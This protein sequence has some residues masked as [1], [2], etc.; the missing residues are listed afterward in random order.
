MKARKVLS[1]ITASVLAWGAFLPIVPQSAEARMETSALALSWQTPIGEGTTLQKYYKSYANQQISIMVTKVDLNNPY[2]EVKPVY[3]TK[4]KLT[5]RQSVTNMAKETGAVAAINVDFFNMSKR[6]APFGIVMKDRELISSMGLISYWYSLGLTGDKTAMIEKF[7]FT[8][9]VTAQNGAAYPLQGVNKEE[10]NPSEGRKSHFNQM[11]LYTPKFGKTSLGQIPGYNTVE[12]VFRNN[13]A[14]EVRVNQPGAPIPEDG[15]VL[16]GNGPAAV[17]LQQNFPVGSTAQV[18]YATLPN[19][20]D[21]A[22]AV[23]GSILLVDQGVAKTSFQ[24]DSYLK[25][26]NARTAVGISQDGKTLYMVTVDGAKPVYLEE[27]A[28]IMVELGAWRALNL[29]GGGSTTHAA[30]MLGET[31]AK[32]VSQPKE[33]SER[34]VPTGLAVYNTAPPGELAGFQIAGPTE[35]LMGQTATFTTK[36]WDTHYLPYKI[37]PSD[38]EWQAA[39]SEAGSFAGNVF[40]A[41]RPGIAS[42]VA[43]SNG[44]AQ[45]RDIYVITGQD[46]AQVVVSPSPINMVPGQTLTLDVKV[47]TKKGQTINATPQSVQVWSDSD[48]ITVDSDKLQLIAGDQPGTANITVSYDGVSTT[49]PVMSGQEIEVPWL[50]FDNQTSMYHVGHPASISAYGS[51]KTVSGDADLVYRTKKS[52]QLS[53]NFAGA[54]TTDVRI[55]YG[56]VGANPVTIPGNPIGIGLWVNGDGSN[57]WLRAEVVDAKGKLTY[58]DLAKEIN[59]TGWKQVKG[60][61][62]GGVTYPLQLKSI[63]VVD[64]PDDQATQEQGVLYFDEVSLLLP[65]NAATQPAGREVVPA[66]PGTLSLGQEL[67]MGYSLQKTAGFLAKARID[68]KSVAGQSMPGYV[69]A[70]Y[71]FTLTPVALQAGQQDQLATHPVTITLTPKKWMNGKGVGLMYVNEVNNTLDMLMGQVDAKGNWVYEINSYGTYIPYYLDAPSG[72]AFV[73]IINHPAQAE[74]T[75]LANRGLVKGMDAY[76][77]GPEVPLTRA[78]FVTLLGRAFDWKL[79]A[80]P[81]VSFKDVIPDYAKGSVQVAVSKGLVKGYADKTFRPNQTVTRAEAAVILDRVLQKKA[82]PKTAPADKKSWPQW[83]A[84]SINNMAGLGLID[85]QNNRFEPNKP[86]TRAVTAVALYRSLE[87]N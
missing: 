5:E 1:L 28:D 35:M 43:E 11:N 73:D 9:Q 72:V 75:S 60:F 42:I 20:T 23:G 69:P 32:L 54:P 40:T 29:D 52:A 84:S 8:G 30:R 65:K 24:V 82:T 58:V 38:I 74:I 37:D 86:M 56:R 87:K 50:T 71:S 78:Q 6:G 68:V 62:P 34:R 59:W 26:I 3:G 79:P 77:F 14:T 2:V 81:K 21:W 47:K 15:Y 55:A 17:F 36:A 70:D 25:Q 61:V 41:T 33:G 19:T 4:G 16:W 7:G 18:S 12:V 80:Q 46:V 49:V 63:Y 22:Q 67:D 48:A 13:V 44:I 27:M 53:Y 10:Y 57:H 85:P 83:A 39:Q 51:F 64:R 31:E 76:H 66:T 45:S